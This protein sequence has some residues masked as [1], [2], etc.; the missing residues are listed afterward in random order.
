MGTML[1]LRQEHQS[2]NHG[3]MPNYRGDFSGKVAVLVLP[4]RLFPRVDN[5]LFTAALFPAVLD[6]LQIDVVPG[7]FLSKEH[8]GIPGVLLCHSRS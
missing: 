7:T 4:R 6:D 2:H 5:A 3:S 8:G 1:L